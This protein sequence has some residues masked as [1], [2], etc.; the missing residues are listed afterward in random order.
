MDYAFVSTNLLDLWAKPEFNSE[1][2]HQLY[3][4][5]PVRVHQKKNNYWLVEDPGIYKGWGHANGLTE[6]S[7]GDFRTSQGKANA[8]ITRTR[9][10]LYDTRL[11]EKIEPYCLYYGNRLVVTSW[12]GRWGT[13]RLPS[14]TTCRVKQDRI[15]PIHRT[16]VKRV[17]RADLVK[18]AKRFLGVP[19]LWGGVT[20]TG[21][22]CSGFVHT[23]CARFG[24][25]LPRDTKDQIFAGEEIDRADVTTGDLLFFK[26]HV[27]FAIG[28]SKLI[29]ASVAGGGVRIES[30]DPKDPKYRE[31]LDRSF[32]EA[33]R[34]L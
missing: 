31:D 8:V 1:R 29:H 27:G 30:L 23:I 21:F 17:N 22:D 26:R 9:T 6:L 24:M 32:R 20:T 33:R 28:K 10:R 34:L 14:G 13:I 15:N 25:V 16:K 7:A 4:S 2:V 11:D 3:F 19:Y 18:E 5:T 12:R